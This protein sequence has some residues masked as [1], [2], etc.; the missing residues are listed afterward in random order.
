M[1]PEDV[2]NAIDQI[3]NEPALNEPYDLA[4]PT[5]DR[6]GEIRRS[7]RS[8]GQ[9]KVWRSPPSHGRCRSSGASYNAPTTSS[10]R[11]N[12]GYPLRRHH[13]QPVNHPHGDS[14]IK[15]GSSDKTAASTS[16]TGGGRTGPHHW[17]TA[18]RGARHPPLQSMLRRTALDHPL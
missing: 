1:E 12:S 8:W 6:D 13:C 10:A 3:L 16:H 15:S 18:F 7:R 11:N 17:R 2:L 4:Y 9:Q 5:M 14:D